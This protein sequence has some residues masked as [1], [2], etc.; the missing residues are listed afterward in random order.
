[1][2]KKEKLAQIVND[3]KSSDSTIAT[4]AI[5]AFKKNGTLEQLPAFLLNGLENENESV[6]RKTRQLLFDIKD[7]RLIEVLFKLLSKAE[8]L[9]YQKILVAALW[10]ANLDCSA[11]LEELIKLCRSADAETIV[12]IS[13]VIDTLEPTFPFEEIENYKLDLDELIQEEPDEIRAN[14]LGS[15][16]F[17]LDEIVE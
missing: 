11:Y 15:L 7:K 9:P 10:E 6:Q 13:T 5:E 1:M 2:S 14:M 16:L 4:N 3:A 17:L 8:F 12:E